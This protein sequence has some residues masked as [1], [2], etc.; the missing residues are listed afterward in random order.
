MMTLP[1]DVTKQA[2]MTMTRTPEE[3]AALSELEDLHVATSGYLG[4][5]VV[6]LGVLAGAIAALQFGQK[7]SSWFTFTALALLVSV[8]LGRLADSALL[9]R[10][11]LRGARVIAARHGVSFEWLVKTS[12]EEEGS[13][14][15]GGFSRLAASVGVAPAA[16][17]EAR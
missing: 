15:R 6:A 16:S 3:T 17:I 2:T 7:I 10:R 12:R 4:Y 13:P 5:S 11:W 8:P 1:F 14:S 9:R